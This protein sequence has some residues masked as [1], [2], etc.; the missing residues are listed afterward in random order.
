[1]PTKP[2]NDEKEIYLRLLGWEKYG[3]YWSKGMSLDDP[4]KFKAWW[5]S[6]NDAYAYETNDMETGT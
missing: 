5:W 2:T 4:S 3:Q 6:L 1:M